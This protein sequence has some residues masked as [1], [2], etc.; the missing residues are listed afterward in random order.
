M[1]YAIRYSFSHQMHFMSP[2]KVGTLKIDSDAFYALEV[3]YI[4]LL[5]FHTFLKTNRGCIL[6]IY[7]DICDGFLTPN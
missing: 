7:S 2:K 4:L 6:N 1:L 5:R 3:I